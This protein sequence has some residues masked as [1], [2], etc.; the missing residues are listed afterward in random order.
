MFL[1]DAEVR[2]LIVSSRKR[3]HKHENCKEKRAEARRKK[4][5]VLP[6]CLILRSKLVENFLP[7]CYQLAKSRFGR[8]LEDVDIQQSAITGLM[9]ALDRYDPSFGNT[10]MTYATWYIRR[11]MQEQVWKDYLVHPGIAT[12]RQ[13]EF[14]QEGTKDKPSLD[15]KELIETALTILSPQDADVIQ[16]RYFQGK[17]QRQTGVAMR[18]TYQRISQRETRALERLREKLKMLGITSLEDVYAGSPK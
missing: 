6:G 1:T 14:M 12:E 15:N 2:S 7:Y 17:S 5:K 13:P 11:G 3:C 4:R 10:F 8:Y 16:F 18:V 9:M